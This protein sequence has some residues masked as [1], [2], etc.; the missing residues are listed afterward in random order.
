MIKLLQFTPDEASERL[1]H[2]QLEKMV[3]LLTKDKII[4]D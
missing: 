1:I 2:I 3:K 4:T